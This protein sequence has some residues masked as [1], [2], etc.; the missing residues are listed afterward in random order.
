MKDDM[1]KIVVKVEI[2]VLLDDRGRFDPRKMERLSMV[3]ANVANSGAAILIVTSGA[4]FLGSK[5]LGLECQPAALVDKQ[6]VA[7]AG[8]AELMKRY[9]QY[10]EGYNRTVAQVLLTG[11]IFADAE[12][13]RNA[14]NT[15]LYLLE[16]G[17]IPVINENDSVSTEDIE[18]N[19]NYYLVRSVAALTGA[20]L[21]LIKAK[22][23][24]LYIFLK[25]GEATEPRFIR[26]K[27]LTDEIA[28]MAPALLREPS[29]GQAF[30]A[31]LDKKLLEV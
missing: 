20:H 2:S 25:G 11:D 26:E 19:D 24:D 15:L 14:R 30:P 3:L 31:S 29:P 22:K 27:E 5:K 10:F 16:L 4:I 12:K 21:V 18:L 23:P 17:V 8:Q 7:A 28:L 6:A 13:S 9:R 1:I